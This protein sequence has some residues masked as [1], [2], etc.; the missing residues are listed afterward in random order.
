MEPREKGCGGSI[1]K[2]I[3]FS[4]REGEILGWPQKNCSMSAIKKLEF[5]FFFLKR[6]VLLFFYYILGLIQS[7]SCHLG[8][9]FIGFRPLHCI[10]KGNFNLGSIW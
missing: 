10:L 5:D 3:S 6:I 4:E 7:A 2:L 9:F 8:E 1:E